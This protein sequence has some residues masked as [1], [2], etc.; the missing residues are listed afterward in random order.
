MRKHKYVNIN[1]EEI[2]MH[3]FHHIK[4][5]LSYIYINYIML[6]IYWPQK[7]GVTISTPKYTSTKKKD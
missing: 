2:S 3:Q 4:V 1:K 5:I 7:I 6:L